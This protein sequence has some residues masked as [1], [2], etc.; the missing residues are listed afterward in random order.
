MIE[1]FDGS[2]RNKYWNKFYEDGNKT[3]FPSQFAVMLASTVSSE[4]DIVD[5]GCGNGRDTFFFSQ[6]GYRVVGIDQSEVAIRSNLSR[7]L[8]GRQDNVRFVQ[9][10]F[11]DREK[12]ELAANI[13]GIK[14]KKIYYCRFVL[15]SITDDE[16]DKLFSTL[17]ELIKPEDKFYAEFRT[18]KD[19]NK[20]KI[21]GSHFRRFLNGEAFLQRCSDRGLVPDYFIEG[22]G[23]AT[24]RSED[25]VV[26]RVVLV[27]R[28]GQ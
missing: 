11:S 15:H 10:N 1:A 5:L 12:I 14:S 24:F 8:G 25:P 22:V 13:N 18:E 6:L 9:A 16:E 28:Y 23:M 2:D 4:F 27:K 3:I 17:V 20:E 19:R 7:S 21:F 26:A